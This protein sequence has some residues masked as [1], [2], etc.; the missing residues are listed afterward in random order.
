MKCDMHNKTFYTVINCFIA[1]VWFINGLLCKILNFVPRHQ[2]IVG[3]ILTPTYAR[4][5]T[6][7]IGLAEIGMSVLVIR[8][9]FPKY[10]AYL[11]IGIILSMNILE[12]LLVPDLLLWGKLNIIFALLFCILIYLN[13]HFNKPAQVHGIS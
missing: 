13:N 4:E 2:Q 10:L 11:Q 1:L 5:L 3:E 9:L 6:F 12:F 8:Q 7:I